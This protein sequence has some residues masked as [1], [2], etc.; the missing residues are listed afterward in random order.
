MAGAMGRVVVTPRSQFQLLKMAADSMKLRTPKD[1]A[2][3]RL[4]MSA[5]DKDLASTIGATVLAIAFE[6]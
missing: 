4:T 3:V 2:N 5:M 6:H 1:Q